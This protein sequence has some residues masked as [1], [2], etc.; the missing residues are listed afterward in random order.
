MTRLR[1]RRRKPTPPAGLHVDLQQWDAL[2]LPVPERSV[3]VVLTNPP[4]GKRIQIAGGE[5]YPFYRHILRE[6]RRVLTP[7]GRL[8]LLTSQTAALQHGV[9]GSAAE[10]AIQRRVPLLVRGERATIFVIGAKGEG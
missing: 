9:S 7:N 3:E 4:F 8:V 6:A 10:W 2:A 5:I 1:W